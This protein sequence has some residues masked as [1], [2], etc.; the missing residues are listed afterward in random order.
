MKEANRYVIVV[1]TG[2]KR[3]EVIK[4]LRHN[5]I[6]QNQEEDLEVVQPGI[7][8]LEVYKITENVNVL[9]RSIVV[10]VVPVVVNTDY[11]KGFTGKVHF[12]MNDLINRLDEI[13]SDLKTLQGTTI[14]GR[15]SNATPEGL[16]K[17][18]SALND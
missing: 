10:V 1:T 13:K 12:V 8:R 3:D 4:R 17:S 16:E 7:N 6:Y 5:L 14:L 15:G 11:I 18:L 9:I 2:R